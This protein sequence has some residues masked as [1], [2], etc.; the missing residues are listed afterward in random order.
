M[1]RAQRSNR[2][3][4]MIAGGC[5]AVMAVG[6]T[7]AYLTAT[8][9]V[10]NDFTVEKALE[11]NISVI[12]PNWDPD[13]G[14]N[15]VPTQTISKDPQLKN[16]SD[17]PVYAIMQISVPYATVATATAEGVVQSTIAQDLFTYSVNA[18]WT[19]EG[20]GTLSDDGTHMIHTYLMADQ[21]AAGE[22]TPSVFDDVTLVNAIDGQVDGMNLS[23]DV[24]GFAIQ[25][26]GFESAADAWAAYQ[27]QNNS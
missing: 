20:T 11:E 7:L 13:N 8:D 26:E 6:G 3:K 12:E 23:I 5:A 21:L 4:M 10:T 24:N 1:E 2:L 16:D 19:E 17:I 27:N 25:A 15:I 14:V 18:G 22:T 9:G